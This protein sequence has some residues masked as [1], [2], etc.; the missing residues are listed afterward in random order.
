MTGLESLIAG[1]VRRPFDREDLPV[2]IRTSRR[3]LLAGATATA[4]AACLIAATASTSAASTTAT[5]SPSHGSDHSSRTSTPIKHVVVIYDENVS[6]DHYFATY[7]KAANT[8][9]TKFV[10]AKKT[11][12]ANT[13]SQAGLLKNNPNLYQPFRLSPAQALTCDQNHNYG[14]EQKAAD[15]GKNDKYVQNTSVDACTGLYGAPGLTM[16]YYDGNTVTALW[17]YAQQ[18]AQ[19]DN[20]Y[21]STFG[22]STPGALNLIS[23]QTHG[24]VAVNPTTGAQ[25][26]PMPT[27]W[28][29]PD[30][31]GV[32]TVI[33]DPDP[34]FDDCS[35]KDHTSTNNLAQL[36]GKNI[37][38][39]LN[40]QGVTWGWFQGGFRPTTAYAGTGTLR[41]VRRQ[42]HQRRRR[43][44]S[45]DYSPHHYAVPVLQV[46]LEPAPPAAGIG[47]R[48]RPH[49]SGQPQLRPERF[50]RLAAGRI[51]AGRQLPQGAGVPGRPRR[52]LRSDR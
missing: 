14:P 28:S 3:G 9:G 26:S 7:P 46:D 36:Q 43:D 45:V 15:A 39:L 24:A 44:R 8:D 42:P 41:Q 4:A 22:P 19:S 35:D 32:G 47:V 52:L 25:T 6:Y 38:D 21:S 34:A 27:R 20:S 49:R 37:G 18:F 48:H 30:A 50:R 5:V 12:A 51:A 2:P 1:R 17:N 13:L 10:A 16:G 11:P 31:N 23:G 33:N 40:Q 29:S